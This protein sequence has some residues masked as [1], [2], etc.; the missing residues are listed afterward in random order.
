MPVSMIMT[1]LKVGPA[2]T[3]VDAVRKAAG[4]TPLESEA[5]DG[6]EWYLWTSME[7]A[8]EAPEL[9]NNGLNMVVPR[10]LPDGSVDPDPKAG[11][12]LRYSYAHVEADNGE[13]FAD[14]LRQLGYAILGT[15]KWVP[16]R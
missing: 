5:V 12:W 13:E 1:P 10:P 2:G 3:L 15:F 8:D 14:G 4:G 16:V 9:Q 6:A 7:R 11:L